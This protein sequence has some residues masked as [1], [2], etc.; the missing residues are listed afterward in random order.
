M[1]QASRGSC[2]P[3]PHL[4]HLSPAA[5]PSL[6]LSRRGTPS[7]LLFVADTSREIRRASRGVPALP[8]GAPPGCDVCVFLGN[9]FPQSVTSAGL[10]APLLLSC[11]VN[12][13][14]SVPDVTKWLATSRPCGRGRRVAEHCEGDAGGAGRA[15]GDWRACKRLLQGGGA[16]DD[17][18][19][20]GTWA[21][22][23]RLML[24]EGK[25]HN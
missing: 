6:F 23:S 22:A 5:R 1:S 16:G 12:G 20:T 21:A 18:A 15:G 25:C 17:A 2:D 14:G 19:H 13:D 24:T 3:R 7:A 8:A 10:P 4:K 11:A 9:S